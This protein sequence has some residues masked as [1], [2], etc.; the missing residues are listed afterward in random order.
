[1]PE[2]IQASRPA[3]LPHV[4]DRVRRPLLP[5]QV[6]RAHGLPLAGGATCA[7]SPNRARLSHESSARPNPPGG[8][9]AH[10]TTARNRRRRANQPT[11]ATSR[12]IQPLAAH[13]PDISLATRLSQFQSE[14]QPGWACRGTRRGVGAACDYSIPL[15]IL[16]SSFRSRLRVLGPVGPRHDASDQ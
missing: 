15:L 13:Q 4:L 9:A 10:P 5:H 14:C 6:L 3:T 7:A 1:M 2:G 16:T 8:G 11:T 12:L